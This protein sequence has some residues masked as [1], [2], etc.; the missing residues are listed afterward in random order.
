[1]RSFEYSRSFKNRISWRL[2]RLSVTIL[3]FPVLSFAL[4]DSPQT[5]TLDGQ[6]LIKGS[7]APLLDTNVK[8]TVQVLNP[9]A[10]CVLYEEQQTVNT[11][12]SNGYFTIYVGSNVGAGKRT[13]NDP[14][15]SMNQIF[16]NTSGIVANSAA[17]QTCAGGAYMPVPGA[18]R[19][20]RVVVTPSST[21][22]PDTLTPDIV[23]DAVPQ[24]LVAQSVQG[25]E[26]ANIL[27]T[28]VTASTAL[29]QP[30]L[31]ALFTT[32]AYPN[33]QSILAGNFMRTDAS[34][35]ALPS[36]ASNPSSPTNGE[37]W[38]DST[39]G[40][41]KYKNAS[42][43]QVVG[44]VGGGTISSLTVGSSMSL[45]GSVAATISN[46]AATMDLANSGISAGTYT[47]LTVDMKGRA[48]AGVVSLVEADIPTLTL[49]GKVSGDAITSGAISG[50][51]AI[52]TSGNLF[53]AGMISGASLQTAN[54]RVSGG[55]IGIG[56]PT[57]SLALDISGGL[58]VGQGPVVTTALS[59]AHLATD[60]TL[61]V[62]NTNNYPK[63][64]MLVVNGTE[65]VSY[66][67]TTP[68]SFTG[69]T[70]GLQGTT[71]SA[72]AS[73]VSTE[74][75][76][77]GAVT[78]PAA[79][80][81][82]VVTASNGVG[83]GAVPPSWLGNSSLYTAGQIFAQT[84]IVVGT[85]NAYKFGTSSSQIVGNGVTSASDYIYFKTNV[86]ERMRID[87]VGRVGMGISNPTTALQVSGE[88]APAVDNNSSLGD[89]SLRFT[90]VY[91]VNG[92][93][94]TSDARLKTNIS[95]SDLGLQFI[96]RLRPVSYNWNSGADSNL[97]YGLI[98][99]EAEQAV[100]ESRASSNAGSSSAPIVDHDEKTDRY[101]IRY[102]ELISP[103][104][105]AVQEIYE[106]VTGIQAENERLRNENA[107]IRARLERLERVLNSRDR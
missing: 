10:T 16:Q 106:M 70:R 23:I 99:Q 107:E 9:S 7:T 37:V 34:G 69:V 92:T 57:P 55:S 78:G 54:L 60:T 62:A 22:L 1:M 64:G 53:S 61:N 84:G 35:A 56:M 96:R 47:K 45:N 82:F 17:G 80:P 31:E 3:I 68:T 26:R 95:D 97:H 81:R 51:T 40:E 44:A 25:L 88:I 18:V 39:T 14:G 29:T 2:V 103:V 67:G 24:A 42:G 76:L 72:L 93:I 59:G 86:S 13:V 83:V 50:S 52:N 49:G 36:Y 90:A 104:I 28:A 65:V 100:L 33:L 85:A 63:A 87:G 91:A 46:G 58:R 71:A 11:R 101:G 77:F 30:N 15:R 66:T 32:S 79:I 48:T 4:N 43:V 20:F 12:D 6:L 98:A 75:W 27:Q 38:F 8:I 41:V 19:Y 21:L 73:G 5:F 94:Q 102:A 105:K 74:G 89:A